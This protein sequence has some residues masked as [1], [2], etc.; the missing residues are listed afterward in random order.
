[1]TRAVEVQ[2]I[3][4]DIDPSRPEAA[5][6][7]SGVIKT[8]ARSVRGKH[9]FGHL[10]QV[11]CI[12]A[13]AADC[14]AMGEDEP[15]VVTLVVLTPRLDGRSYNRGKIGTR[16]IHVTQRT[17]KERVNSHRDLAS[18]ALGRIPADDSKGRTDFGSRKSG[19]QDV[20]NLAAKHGGAAL[21]PQV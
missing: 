19:A 4:G 21:E 8:G 7:K 15:S 2:S 10:S 6:D 1:M 12:L 3:G 20:R 11:Q 13:W 16:Q 14:P 18:T 5:L 17:G 9:H